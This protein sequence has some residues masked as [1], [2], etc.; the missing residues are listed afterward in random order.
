MTPKSLLIAIACG[1]AAALAFVSPL[2]LGAI[3]VTLSSFT[4]LPLFVVAL[5]FG[6]I[7]G[8]I[9][10]LVAAI[11]IA[12]FFGL[13][14]A[15]AVAAATLAP[16]LIIGHLAGLVRNEVG[17]EEW[18]P[19]SGI[20]TW[21]VMISAAIALAVL[22][23]SGYSSSWAEQQALEVLRTF[24]AASTGGNGPAIS[25]EVI[26]RQATA[27]ANLIP[28]AMPASVLLLMVINLHIAMIVARANGWVL[29]P[30]D[31]VPSQTALPIW[32]A[33][34]F[35][36]SVTVS[37]LGG[38][39]GLGAQIVAGAT[40][41]GFLLVGLATTHFLVRSFRGHSTMLIVLYFLLLISRYLAFAVALLGVAE[42]LFGLRARRAAP[43]PST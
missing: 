34:V 3:G 2:S 15:L 11:I 42:T 12:I 8:A 36:A 23:M 13:L 33:G 14:P 10:G 5:G 40:G 32:M 41:A 35:I 22:G 25:E 24:S 26:A 28:I 37:L 43:P 16:A 7:A 20:L 30:K 6:T 18:Y 39:L 1:L 38:G 4:A 21:M 31:H 9:A 19:L 29:R 17:V 27:I